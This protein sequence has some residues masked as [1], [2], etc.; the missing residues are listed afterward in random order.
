MQY[1]LIRLDRFSC[2]NIT[3]HVACQLAAFRLINLPANDLSAKNIHEQIQ[4]KIDPLDWRR[5]IRD[6]P[7]K[8]LVRRSGTQGAWFV[9]ML[10]GAFR[11]SMS[12][13]IL[14]SKYA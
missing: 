13:L 14:C 12:K 2:A 1:H 6:V 4:I 7:G 3:H 11:T 10:R 8:Q 9:A 5:Q